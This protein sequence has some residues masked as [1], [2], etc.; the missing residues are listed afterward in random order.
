MLVHSKQFCTNVP[1]ESI[2][3]NAVD[4]TLDQVFRL[5]DVEV[6]ISK[7]SASMRDRKLMH[8][9]HSRY[10]TEVATY[11]QFKPGQYQFESNIG[12]QLPAGVVGWVVARSTLN[13]NGIFIISGLFDS[14]Y[15]SK[16]IGATMYVSCDT[17]IEAGAR[18]AQF[19]T[20]NAETSH[21]YS[22]QWQ[23]TGR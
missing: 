1:P 7:D 12:C 4:I 22:G 15:S 2:Q 10:G 18:V 3:P 14:G 9:S 16:T 20:M 23:G 5:L 6:K 11:Y 19:V 8:P 13:R 21:L 17:E